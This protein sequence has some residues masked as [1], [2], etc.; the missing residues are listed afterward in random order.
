VPLIRK[1]SST[2]AGAPAPPAVAITHGSG[3]DRWR[4]VRAAGPDDVAALGTTLERETDPRLREAVL[5]SLVRIGTPQAARVTMRALRSDD[6][7]LRTAAL[8]ALRAMPEAQASLPQLLRDDDADVRLLA[9]E[10]ARTLP[11]ADASRLLTAFLDS[12]PHANACAA[13]VE[14]LAEVGGTEVLPALAR[15]AQRFRDDPFLAFAIRVATDR[16]VQLR[17]RE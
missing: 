9:C 10:L 6:A 11:A 5:T 4:A 3:D 7:Q 17:P 12:E 14:V 13:A 8:D 15:C 2:P 1:D 16:I